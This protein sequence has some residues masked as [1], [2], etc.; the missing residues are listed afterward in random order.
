MDSA[1]R[2]DRLESI[3][4]IRQLAYGYALAVDARDLDAVSGLYIDDIRVGAERGREALR[5]VFDA[6]LRQFTASAHHVTNHLVEF[7]DSDTA[8]G[9][10]NCRI[11]HEVGDAWVTASL[12]YHDRYVRREGVWLFRG[13]VQTR[14]YATSHD[15]PPVGAA[16]LRWPGAAAAETGF[17]DALPSW[18][19]F[20]AGERTAW[21]GQGADTLVSRLRRGTGLPPPPR[22]QFKD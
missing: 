18:G 4:A 1:A 3:E 2:L 10:V 5:A 6:S 14:L 17:H 12:L 19:E 7:I 20:W 8:I 9:L 13:R 15:D 21:D 22:Y 11:E 16:K